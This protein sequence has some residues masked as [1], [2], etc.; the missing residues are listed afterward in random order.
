MEAIPIVAFW[1][2]AAWATVQQRHVLVYALFASMP[3]GA[4]AVIPTSLT[5][6]LTLTPAPILTLIFI[7]REL[8][9]AGGLNYA[10]SSALR[11]SRLLLLFL[12]WLV[13]GIVTAFMPR[14]FA[15]RVEIVPMRVSGFMETA[16]LVPTTQNISQFVYISIS[17]LAVFAFSRALA[18]VVMRRHVFLALCLGA[19]V[20][21][22]TGLLDFAS[23]Y[24]PLD[25]ILDTFRTANY[26]LLTTDEVLGGKRVV[27]LLPEASSFGSL[28]LTFLTSLYFFRR[29][30][31]RGFLTTRV[32]PAL[33]GSLLLLVWMSTSS[34]AYLGLGVFGVVAVVEWCW[35]AMT[36]HDNPYLRRGILSEF[37]LGALVLTVLMLLFIAMPRIF[38]PV[39]EMLD[40]MV[41]Q[42]ST[43]SSYEERSMWTQVSW[44]ALLSTFG[45]GVGMGATRASNFAV[46]LVSSAGFLGGLLYFSFVVQC[47]IVR[48]TPKN[49]LQGHA[50]LA[51]I[52]WCFLPSFFAGL[53]VGTTPDFGV[54]NAFLFGFSVALARGNLRLPVLV[55]HFPI[56]SALKQPRWPKVTTKRIFP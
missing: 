55:K 3:F 44:N 53:T 15:G 2:L 33:M 29:A 16:L 25:A 27:G 51:A 8:S 19:V 47:L 7:V 1:C 38:S 9:V 11:P 45:L 41:F 42:K 50:M 10:V 30:V 12:F 14:F 26:S 34:A 6:G 35:R 40:V 18:S 24:M 32:V 31:P 56:R 39:Q 28:S 49:D 21:I 37:Y 43:S 46:A 36:A 22:L 20:T 4:L 52:R 17:V 23:Q 5:A 54:F 13:A 48:R